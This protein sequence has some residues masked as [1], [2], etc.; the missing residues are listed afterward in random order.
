MKILNL[1]AGIGG[2]RKDWSSKHDVTAVELNEEIAEVYQDFFPNDEIVV[3][4]AHEYLKEHFRDFDFIWSSPP[5]PTH[6][7]MRRV[8]VKVHD[9]EPKYPDLKLFEEILFLKNFFDG[10]WVVENVI[11]YYKSQIDWKKIVEPQRSGRHYFWS[12]LNIPDVEYN[13]EQNIGGNYTLEGLQDQR[14]IDLS[15]Y[16]MTQ[17]KKI[18]MLKNMVDSRIGQAILNARSSKQ[19]SLMEV[20]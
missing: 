13:G 6:S 3:A 12:N 9:F 11:P 16:N 8:G 4:D 17:D 15:S 19:Q 10:D 7:R 5:C 2:N 1:Y 14:G 18:K 20:Q